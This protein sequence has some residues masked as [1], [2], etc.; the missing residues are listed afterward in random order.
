[1]KSVR[2]LI[3][4]FAFIACYYLLPISTRLLWQ[5]DETRYAEISREM[6]ASGDWIVPHLLGLRYFEKPIAGYWINSIGQ[7]LFGA[8]NFGV[9]AGVIFA[10]LLTAALVTW[11]TLRLWRDKRLALLATVIYLS[12]FI[13][14]A[15]GT[16]AVLDPFI[17]FWLVAGM[18]SFWLAMQAQTWKGKSAG[19]LLLGITCGMGVMTKGFLALAVPVLSVLPWVATQ[20]RW[21]D[22]FIYGWLA[23]ISCVLT[24]LPW[25]LAIAQREPDFWHYFSGLS[26]FNALHWMMPNIELRSGTTCRSSLPVACRGWDYSRCTVHRLEKPQAFRNRLFVELDDNA[27][28]VFLRR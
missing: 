7:W 11:F 3:G 19:F 25:G 9:R 14:Y 24:V 28:A 23:V 16:Y 21:K 5:P 1:M 4:L 26:I 2:Y 8:N 18:C 13:V 17:A 10:T 15:I 6:L 12:L 22:L 20:K 27:A